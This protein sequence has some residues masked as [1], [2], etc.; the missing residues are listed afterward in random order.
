MERRRQSYTFVSNKQLSKEWTENN[1]SR[2][3]G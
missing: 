1:G 2:N 3:N